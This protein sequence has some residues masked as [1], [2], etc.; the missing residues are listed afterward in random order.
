[1]WLDNNPMKVYVKVQVSDSTGLN[2][3]ARAEET[4]VELFGD[5]KNPKRD[6]YNTCINRNGTRKVQKFLC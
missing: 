6:S 5:Q 1:M 2:P 4:V 3:L